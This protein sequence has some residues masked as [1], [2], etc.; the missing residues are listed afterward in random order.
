MTANGESYDYVVVGGGTAGAIVAARLSEDASVSVCLLEAGP[1]DVGMDDVLQ[2]R[3]WLSL[4]EGPIDLAYT[5]TLQP[6]GNAHI[7]HSRAA[8]LGGCSSHNTQIYFKPFPGDWQ[9]WV[10][11]GAEGWDADTMEPYYQRLLTKHQIVAEKDRNALLEDWIPSAARAAGVQANPDWNAGPFPDGAGFLDVGYDPATGVRSSSSV[12]YLHPIMGTRPNLDIRTE[13]W[14]RR[15]NLE[16]GRAASISTDSGDIRAERE[17]VVCGGS[18]DTPR[19]LLLSGIGRSDD[20]RALGIEVQHDL[21]GVGENLIDHPES[22]IIWELNQPMPPEGAMDADCA[23]FVN[24]LGKDDRPDLMYHTYQMPFTYNTERLGYPVPDHVICMT[25]NIPR[26]RSVGRMWLLSDNPHVKPAL[27]FQ[28]FT[29]PEGYDEQT[30]VD[31]LKIAREV[32]AT[33]PFKGWLKREVAPG[34]DVTSDADLSTY[35]RA[36]HHTVYHPSGTC[37]MGAASDDTAVVDPE[38][39]VRGVEGLSI[40]D[41]SIFPTMPTV[42]PMVATF[43]IGERCADLVR[44][45]T[46]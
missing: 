16:N 22:I 27:D 4:L 34:L 30:I 12:A 19:L 36:V 24:R 44:A 39:R 38:L 43:M 29:D 1:S 11:R 45:R 26:S 40:A 2:L 7:V 14:V 5:T 28:Y 10:D 32:A 35:G 3:R 21:P 23:L 46:S 17:I 37:K 31:G 42:N 8:V 6:H 33:E 9:D 25:P 15:V 20:L 13:T 18:V 41:G